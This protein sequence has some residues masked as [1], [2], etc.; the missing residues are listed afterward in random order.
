MCG[1][2]DRNHPAQMAKVYFA[3]RKNECL[4]HQDSQ[5]YRIG[6]QQQVVRTGSRPHQALR[7]GPTH[8]ALTPK[9]VGNGVIC[10]R[11]ATKWHVVP[12]WLPSW[13][14][15]SIL[16]VQVHIRKW[17]WRLSSE[18]T[19]VSAAA[20]PP[21]VAVT[22]GDRSEHPPSPEFETTLGGTNA[23]MHHRFAA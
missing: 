19:S 2:G 21:C 18:G 8:N 1:R 14:R 5:H 13:N 20:S 9:R 3:A 16:D 12:I 11:Y 4:R 17:A 23:G 15:M 10:W 6:A 22:N 7:T